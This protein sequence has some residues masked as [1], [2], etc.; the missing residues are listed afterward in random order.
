[1]W[2]AGLAIPLDVIAYTW[3]MYEVTGSEAFLIFGTCTVVFYVWMGLA[4]RLDRL[5]EQSKSDGQ[6]V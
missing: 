6:A 2:S 3:I 5:D 1:M 4:H